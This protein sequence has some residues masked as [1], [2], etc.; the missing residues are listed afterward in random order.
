MATTFLELGKRA[1]FSAQ[2]PIRRPAEVVTEEPADTEPA[3]PDGSPSEDGALRPVPT[4]GGIAFGGLVYNIQIHLPESREQA[5]YD[6]IF[7]SL[8]THMMQ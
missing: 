7:R 2:L 4:T 3:T 5:V 8:K 1:D 6:A